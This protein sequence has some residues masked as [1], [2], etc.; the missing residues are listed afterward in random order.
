MLDILEEHLPKKC[1]GNHDF[2]IVDKW[3][4]WKG[5][6]WEKSKERVYKVLLVCRKC[7][8]ILIKKVDDKREQ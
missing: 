2:H 7:S 5:L 3:Y 1:E 4:E 6:Q 8:L